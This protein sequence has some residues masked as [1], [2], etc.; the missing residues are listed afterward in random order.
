M[1]AKEDGGN[2][3]DY[4]QYVEGTPYQAGDKVTNAGGNYECKPHPY[5]GWCA[6]AAWAYAP[7]IGTYWDQ[8]WT[9]I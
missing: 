9:K 7:G 6:G 4:P 5:T 2:P 8:A 1:K 3:G